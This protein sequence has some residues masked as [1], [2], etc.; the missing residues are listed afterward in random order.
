MSIVYTTAFKN[1]KRDTWQTYQR[2]IHEYVNNFLRMCNVFQHPL[3]V[4]I[5]EDILNYINNLS[6]EFSIPPNVLFRNAKSVNTFYDR[7]V[8]KEKQVMSDEKYKNKIP[9]NRRSNPEHLPLGYNAVMHNK[10]NFIKETQRVYPV[11]DYYGWIDFGYLK[12]FLTKDDLPLNLDYTKLKN[13][14]ITFGVMMEPPSENIS[15]EEMMRSEAIFFHGAS[16]I[17]PSQL[18]TEY[19]KIYEDKVLQLY[20]N[21]VSDD[22]QNIVYQIYC[23]HKDMFQYFKMSTWMKLY[24][25]H[26]NCK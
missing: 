1:I 20:D 13:D 22:D 14:K 25:E 23:D 11:F 10:V 24:N 17:V 5:E 19:E 6:Y 9:E 16:F 18:V 12:N 8:E 15:A 4:Y 26:L 2:G 21:Y 7:Y 3:V